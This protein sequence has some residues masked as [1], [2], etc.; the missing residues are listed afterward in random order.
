MPKT[1]GYGTPKSKVVRRVSTKSGLTPSRAAKVPRANK[2]V[3]KAVRKKVST[4][5][6]DS[7]RPIVAGSAREKAQRDKR[8]RERSE[9]VTSTTTTTPKRTSTTTTG[10]KRKV[11]GFPKLKSAAQKNID[12]LK[13]IK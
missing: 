10:P 9:R 1:V 6:A 7:D 2:S 12:R 13:K 11:R 4:V 8:I 3:P 5:G